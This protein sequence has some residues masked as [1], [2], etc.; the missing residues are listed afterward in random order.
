MGDRVA[1]RRHRRGLSTRHGDSRRHP[2]RASR[3]GE[4]PLIFEAE[5]KSAV[6]PSRRRFRLHPGSRVYVLDDLEAIP[7]KSLRRRRYRETH[8][9]GFSAGLVR[10]AGWFTSIATCA[11]WARGRCAT[12]TSC[13]IVAGAATPLSG[14]TLAGMLGG[15]AGGTGRRTHWLPGPSY[16]ICTGWWDTDAWATAWRYAAQMLTVQSQRIVSGADH[17]FR[18]RGSAA[19][20]VMVAGLAAFYWSPATGRGTRSTFWLMVKSVVCAALFG[21]VLLV[22][23]AGS[24]WRAATIRSRPIRRGCRR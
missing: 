9:C 19:N 3:A 15:D 2:Q 5:L 18:G 8:T 10:C 7:P 24:G 11:S 12:S 21:I 14:S 13:L 17:A 6:A 1:D 22:A 16:G 4:R 23:T 20:R